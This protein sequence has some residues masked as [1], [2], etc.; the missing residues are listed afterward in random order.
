MS[1]L[2]AGTSGFSYPTWKP[3]FYPPK[4]PAKHFL[5]VYSSRLNTVE[6]NYTFRH[7]P[8]EKTLENWINQTPP[9]FLFVLKAHQRIT[10][11]ARL[12]GVDEFTSDFIRS[13]APLQRAGRLG[14]VL[15]QLPPQLKSD[16]DRLAAFLDALPSHLRFAFEFRHESWFC[17]P[18]Y[19]ILREHKVALCLAESEKLQVPDVITADFVYFRLRKPEYS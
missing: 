13:L 17:D 10:H 16:A 12:K 14:P 8:S 15:F 2:F 5:S 11:I 3:D 18:V 6:I 1:E 19:Q 7:F 4:T 9:N